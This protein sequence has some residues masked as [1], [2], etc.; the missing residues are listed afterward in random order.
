ME[1]K[2]FSQR[3]IWQF[4]IGE[5]E[6]R[7]KKMVSTLIELAVKKAFEER[8]SEIADTSSDTL[9]LKKTS[10]LTGLSSS[11][12]Y[13]KVSRFEMPSLTRGRPLLFSKK[14]LM[15]WLAS[16]RPKNYLNTLTK[17]L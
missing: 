4:S 12:I 8:A 11:T 17:K 3:P 14:E 2:E 7:L 6:T 13:S 10:E 9:D 16:G 15:T 1:H 5:F